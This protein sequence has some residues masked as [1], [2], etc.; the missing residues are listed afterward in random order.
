MIGIRF[1]GLLA[2]AALLTVEWISE[3]RSNESQRVIELSGL[4]KEPAK[5]AQMAL[6]QPR[7]AQNGPNSARNRVRNVSESSLGRAALRLGAHE[8]CKAFGAHR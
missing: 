2:L 7:N 6:T 4:G 5:E 1:L 3:L 8:L